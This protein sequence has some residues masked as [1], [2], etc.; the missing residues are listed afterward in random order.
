MTSTTAVAIEIGKSYRVTFRRTGPGG[1]VG[2]EESRVW[3][4][5]N[6]GHVKN[7]ERVA[8]L[9]GRGFVMLRTARC[10]DDEWTV[11]AFGEAR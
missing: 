10:V 11:L 9:V 1:M 8:G 7:L 2:P 4:A 3:T 5:K 6:A